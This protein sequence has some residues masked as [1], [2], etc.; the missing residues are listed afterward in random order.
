MKLGLFCFHECPAATGLNCENVLVV[1]P[2]SNKTIT[3]ICNSGAAA[4]R[5]LS[6]LGASGPERAR[7]GEARGLRPPGT[8]EV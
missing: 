3:E 2:K 6:W 5:Q 4:P 8:V 1:L 7:A